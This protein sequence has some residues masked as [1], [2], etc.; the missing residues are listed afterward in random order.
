M[1]I[2]AALRVR[3]A[4][5][6]EDFLREVAPRL[7][8]RFWIQSALP[9]A[10]GES[11][12]LVVELDGSSRHL[13]GLARIVSTEPNRLCVRLTELHPE[14]LQFPLGADGPV[15]EDVLVPGVWRVAVAPP[16]ARGGRL[17]YGGAE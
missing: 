8:G 16:T 10:S 15:I 7:S 14:S 11:L 5:S 1:P 12:P 17:V 2:A 4:R 6:S 3:L 13:R 9:A